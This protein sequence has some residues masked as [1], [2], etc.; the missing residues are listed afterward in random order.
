MPSSTVSVARRDSPADSRLQIVRV[1]Q[2]GQPQVVGGKPQANHETHQPQ[3]DSGEHS[4]DGRPM[5]F[6]R[7]DDIARAVREAMFIRTL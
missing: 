7:Q 4:G 1:S 3:H 5:F 6:D 2:G